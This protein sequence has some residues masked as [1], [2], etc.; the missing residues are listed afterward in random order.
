[1]SCI[2]ECLQHIQKQNEK[3][4]FKHL[5]SDYPGKTTPLRRSFKL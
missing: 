5:L 2:S 4:I 3:L 1:M